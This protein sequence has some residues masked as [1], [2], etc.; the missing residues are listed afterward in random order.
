MGTY[1]GF[2]EMFHG[3]KAQVF[4][5]VRDKLQ[6]RINTW[7]TKFLSKGGKKVLVKFVA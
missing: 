4:A 2:P 6:G 7:S 1:L 5:F 3:S